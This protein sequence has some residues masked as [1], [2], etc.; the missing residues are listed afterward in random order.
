MK[1]SD[2]KKRQPIK[3]GTNFFR[4]PE[5][6]ALNVK[7]LKSVDH[8]A[9]GALLFSFCRGYYPFLEQESGKERDD[10]VYNLNFLMDIEPDRFWEL[11][12]SYQSVKES[13]FSKEFKDLFESLCHESADQRATIA[14]IKKSKWYNG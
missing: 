12:A 2:E 13:T 7:N 6:K 3:N 8:F 1:L 14:D 11:H 5:L 10:E 4:S 9:V